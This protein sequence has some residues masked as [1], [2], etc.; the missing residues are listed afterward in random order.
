[1]RNPAARQKAWLAMRHL[2]VFTLADVEAVTE[3]HYQSCYRYCLA[4]EFSQHLTRLERGGRQGYGR[5]RLLR[6]TGPVA[7]FVTEVRV[8]GQATRVVID[9]N[10]P[11]K[12]AQDRQRLWQA[13]RLKGAFTTADLMAICGCDKAPTLRYLRALVDAGYLRELGKQRSSPVGFTGGFAKVLQLVQNTGP[14]APVPQSGQLFDANQFDVQQFFQ[15]LSN[16]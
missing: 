1:M 13:M 7:P 12:L 14:I 5:L 8:D 15:E 4:L 9:P 6:D 10:L 11:N 2:E 16:A 3:A